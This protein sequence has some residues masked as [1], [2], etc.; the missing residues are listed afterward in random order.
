MS[1]FPIGCRSKQVWLYT[2]EI[3]TISIDIFFYDSNLEYIILYII[4]IFK[5][6]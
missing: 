4:F 6:I 1:V 5:L 2:S 3:L